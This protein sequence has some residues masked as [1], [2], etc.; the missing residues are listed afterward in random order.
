MDPDDLVTVYTL[1]DAN[2]AEIIKGAL[3]AEGIH[4]QLGGEGQAGFTGLWE[5]EVMVRAADADQAR[6]LIESHE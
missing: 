1:T 5:V 6:Q 2:Q 3:Q 4:C